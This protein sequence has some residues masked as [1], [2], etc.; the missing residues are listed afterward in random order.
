MALLL[1]LQAPVIFRKGNPMGWQ[2]GF[3]VPSKFETLDQVPEPKVRDHRAGV[4]LG[5]HTECA[6]EGESLF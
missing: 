1:R 6:Y 5:R 4:Q 2:V 3:F